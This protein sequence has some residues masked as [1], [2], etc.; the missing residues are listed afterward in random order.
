MCRKENQK[1]KMPQIK[2]ECLAS[3]LNLPGGRNIKEKVADN[4]TQESAY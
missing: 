1:Q 2:P 3:L 4:E